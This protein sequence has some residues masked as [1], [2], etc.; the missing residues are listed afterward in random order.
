MIYVFLGKDFEIVSNSINTL[1]SNLNINNVIKYDF[2]ETDLRD[3]LDEVNYIDLFNEK[4]LIIV[5]N[6]SFKKLDEKEEKMFIKY[7]ENMNDN[8][9]IIRCID[10]KLDERKS[11]T[12]L[13]REKCKVEE[14]EALDYKNL[15]EYITNVL[16]NNNF[17][18]TYY[19]V[20][21][22]LDLCDY[23]PDYTINEVNKLLIYK[24]G[25]N[26][27][28]DKDID[29]VIVKNNEKES[30]KFNDNVLDKNVVESLKSFNILVSSG[31]DPVVLIDN[32]ARQYRLLMQIKQ[33]RGKSPLELSRLFGVKEFVI[34]KLIPYSSTYSEEEIVNYLHK[35]SDLDIDIKVN[36]F[37]RSKVLESFIISL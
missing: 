4:K 35:L 31:I 30:F 1:I 6:F 32:L 24:I 29:D 21:K 7:I 37:D 3:I 16:K 26:N 22:I 18:P 17:N 25:D 5:S 15:H 9:I 14:I 27:L 33:Y 20:K 19:Q 34:K 12:K 11:I 10:E 23:N 2:S 36:G 13:L 8:V 28:T